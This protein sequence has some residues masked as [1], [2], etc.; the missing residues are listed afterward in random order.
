[1]ETVTDSSENNIDDA[2]EQ[3]L[4]FKLFDQDYGIEILEVQ[5][6]KGWSQVTPLPNSPKYIKGVLNLRGT[7]VPVIDLRLRFNI[8]AAEYDSFTVIV[9]VNVGGRLAG[10]VV[11]SVSD[12]INLKNDQRC[13]TPE[14]EGQINRQFIEGLGQV[15]EK[16]FILLNAEKLVDEEVLD[17]ASRNTDEN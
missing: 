3:Y 6:I 7:I 10:L 14:F 1:M 4:T 2:E 13:D 8:E 11:D 9:V 15:G 17:A 12:V 16:L 5:E